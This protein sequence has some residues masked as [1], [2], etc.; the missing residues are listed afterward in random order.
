MD[1][2]RK[3]DA[4][5]A[6]V[7]RNTTPSSP[8][9]LLLPAMVIGGRPDRPQRRA[10]SRQPHRSVVNTFSGLSSYSKT[11][12]MDLAY[13]VS[14]HA[15]LASLFQ[16]AWSTDQLKFGSTIQPFTLEEKYNG[17][18]VYRR[19][20]GC[21]V[22]SLQLSARLGDATR[23]TFGVKGQAE[24]TAAS[25]IASSTYT[26]INGKKPFTPANFVLNTALG[27]TT[28]KVQSLDLTFAN[29][30]ADLYGF[31]TNEP[32]DSSLGELDIRGS[33][34]LRFTSLAQYTAFVTA[35]DTSL[36]ITMGH[37]TAE[38]YQLILP[39]ACAYNPDISDPGSTGPHNVSVEIMGKYSSSD[40]TA[41]ILNRAV[42]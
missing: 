22:D 9:F 38:K 14:L 5:I 26:A 32:D 24:A 31:G 13:E 8:T 12:D 33:M 37:T 40:S 42:A 17:T 34:V 23:L 15:I 25:A 18:S 6:E 36:D 11:I 27:L 4:I 29:N 35:A 21:F 3:Q 41:A 30:A 10:R 1:G 20:T 2:S 19:T 28:P 7:T 39:N 16:S